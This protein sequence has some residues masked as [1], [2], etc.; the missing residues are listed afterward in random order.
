MTRS[1]SILRRLV[2]VRLIKDE[3]GAIAA[4]FAF[5]VPLLILLLIGGFDYGRYI[6]L[7]Q[8]VQRTTS[9]VADLAAREEV[10][11][12]TVAPVLDAARY[13]MTPFDLDQRLVV[14]ISEVRGDPDDDP[15]VTWQVRDS[16]W[17]AG[18]GGS[19]PD[20]QIGAEGEVATLREGVAVTEG[21]IL[22][23]AETFYRPSGFFMPQF[24]DELV[25]HQS[26]YRPR[27]G[28]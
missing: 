11:A 8:K 6:L 9:T 1:V 21:E 7:H 20:S 18:A 26:L 16:H 14:I 27:W 12:I 10:D 19:P 13:V 23:I 28:F 15:I 5:T 24:N 17:S 22:I 2:P 3:R 25:Y 4:E